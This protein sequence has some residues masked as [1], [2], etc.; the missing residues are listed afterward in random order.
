MALPSIMILKYM[1]NGLFF[2]I[3]SQHRVSKW[4]VGA[5]ISMNLRQSSE[6][7]GTV[8]EAILEA[9]GSRKADCFLVALLR[10]HDVFVH[11]GELTYKYC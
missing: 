10:L 11:L 5:R 1:Y 2:F 3:F 4:S 9:N 7:S 8:L 6:S